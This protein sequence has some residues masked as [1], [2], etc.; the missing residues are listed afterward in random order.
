MR[1]LRTVIGVIRQFIPKEYK[2]VHVDFQKLQD[3]LLFSPPESMREKWLEAGGI[4]GQL[5]S[6]KPVGKASPVWLKIVANIWLDVS[7]ENFKM[8]NEG[9]LG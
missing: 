9:E 6:M 3:S 5:L 8:W 7:A 1:D 4:L 2:G